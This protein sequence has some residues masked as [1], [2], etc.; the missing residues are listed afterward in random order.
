MS[1]QCFSCLHI[2]VKFAAPF[3]SY[4]LQQRSAV[5][6]IPQDATTE[7]CTAQLGLRRTRYELCCWA[8]IKSSSSN[9]SPAVLLKEA[10]REVLQVASPRLPFVVG[11]GR[12][13]EDVLNFRFAERG[14]QALETRAHALRFRRPNP[15]PQQVHTLRERRRVGKRAV[16]VFT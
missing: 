14:V 4:V 13:I 6:A 3:K 5:D 2:Y 15:E 10:R 9:R 8:E 1:P 16:I 11:A 7:I 12:L